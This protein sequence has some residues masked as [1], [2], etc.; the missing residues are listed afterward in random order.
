MP[1]NAPYP[2]EN[3]LPMFFIAN[4][5]IYGTPKSKPAIGLPQMPTVD[6]PGGN[7]GTLF[8]QQYLLGKIF[9]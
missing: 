1:E 6:M 2:A 8:G 5:H 4:P 7:A 9:E 3:P